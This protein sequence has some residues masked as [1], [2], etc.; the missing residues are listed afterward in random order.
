MPKQTLMATSERGRERIRRRVRQRKRLLLERLEDRLVLMGGIDVGDA[1]DPP[2]PTAPASNGAQHQIVTGFHLGAT[3]SDSPTLPEHE[4]DDGVS[5]GAVQRDRF[6]QATVTLTNSDGRDAFLSAWIDFDNSD[7]WDADEQIAVDLP[8]ESALITS[9]HSFFYDLPNDTVYDQLVHARFRLSSQTG[10]QPTGVAVDG[11]V[12]DYAIVLSDNFH[13]GDANRENIS[14]YAVLHAGQ[15][16]TLDVQVTN[17]EDHDAF[18]DVWVDF[19]NDGFAEPS[20]RVVGARPVEAGVTEHSFHVALDATTDTSLKARVQL[21]GS[22]QVITHDFS[23]DSD[24]PSQQDVDIT[25]VTIQRPWD[26][27]DAPPPFQTLL[28][29]FGAFHR[30]NDQLVIGAPPTGDFDGKPT[31]DANGDDPDPDAVAIAGVSDGIEFSNDFYPGET[32]TVHVDVLDDRDS[33]GFV[34]TLNAWVDFDGSGKWDEDEQIIT[35]APSVSADHSFT[36]PLDVAIGQRLFARFRLGTFFN[37]EPNYPFFITDGEVEDLWIEV[38]PWLDYGD[39]PMG[40]HEIVDID[41]TLTT[42]I[43]DAR[44]RVSESLFLGH[45]VDVEVYN[46]LVSNAETDD[47]GGV[48][49]EEGVVF[50]PLVVGESSQVEIFLTNELADQAYLNAWIDWDGSGAWD[51]PSEQIFSAQP[52]SPGSNL[53]S[54]DVSATAPADQVLYSRFRV[55]YESDLDFSTDASVQLPPLGEVEDHPIIIGAAP[56]DLG[57]AFQGAFPTSMADDGARH[58]VVPGFHLGRERRYGANGL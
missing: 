32:A 45:S 24:H 21:S 34:A 13:L 53:L 54:I 57:D 7:S 37:E 1:P 33:G 56:F 9:F 2:F 48:D 31:V 35:N 46:G 5:F 14:T 25:E 41:G 10:L 51:D 15:A 50:S 39:A 43:H 36:V 20:E 16:A 8:L 47:Q 30:V 55:S 52:L 22:P 17:D 42:L 40:L 28:E 3:V 27:G 4:D 12:E 23:I 49:D 44:H 18:L 29:H 58:V 11:E 26:F 38:A 19:D 6:G